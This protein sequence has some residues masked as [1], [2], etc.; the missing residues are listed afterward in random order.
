MQRASTPRGGTCVCLTPSSADSLNHRI[1][2]HARE[3]DWPC[4]VALENEALSGSPLSP[5]RNCGFL[6]KPHPL[7]FLILGGSRWGWS[8]LPHVDA[9]VV[10]DVTTKAARRE[11]PAAFP[12][13][14]N[15]SPPPFGVHT[16]RPDVD[17]GSNSLLFFPLRSK[18]FKSFFVLPE[19]EKHMGLSKWGFSASSCCSQAPEPQPQIPLQSYSAN[20]VF[21]RGTWARSGA[22][23]GS[24]REQAGSLVSKGQGPRAL[25][26]VAP[27]TPSFP[28]PQHLREHPPNQVLAGD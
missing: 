9:S 14:P 20:G 27:A 26:P 10:S 3:Q 15:P 21:S 8:V 18:S 25:H 22:V 2:L 16:V 13:P 19:E 17:L 11:Q 6:Q 12:A 24:G 28:I 1:T 23:L 4:F 5:S 7:S